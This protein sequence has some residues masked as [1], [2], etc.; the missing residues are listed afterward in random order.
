MF[1]FRQVNDKG[2]NKSKTRERDQKDVLTIINAMKDRSPIAGDTNLRNIETGVVAN[3]SVN[4]DNAK[5]VEDKIIK[6][7]KSRTIF[8]VSFKINDQAVTMASKTSLKIDLETVH[9]DPQLLF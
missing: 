7:M 3:R 5:E 4:T 8:D 2:G 1:D 9:V 6:S